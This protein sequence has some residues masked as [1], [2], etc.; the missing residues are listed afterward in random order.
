MYEAYWKLERKPFNNSKTADFYY[1]SEAHQGAVLKLRY[2]I[3][4]RRGGAVLAGA[5]GLGKTSLINTLLDQMPESYGPLIH[6]V[7]PQMPA[8]QLLA[9]LAD[10][11]APSVTTPTARTMDSCVRRIEHALSENTRAGRHAVV[12]ID[13]AH[14]LRDVDAQELLRLLL[15]FETDG[16]P[17]LTL[18][19]VGQPSVLAHLE[20]MPGLDERIGVKCLLR[21]FSGDETA[22]YVSHRLTA[23]GATRSLFDDAALET[24]HQL[25]LGVPR[26]INR[27][28][29]LALLIGFAEEQNQIHADHVEAVAQEMVTIAPE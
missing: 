29:D 7:F 25:S 17:D 12:V 15:N 21:P 9:Y 3:E 10:E 13:E 2:T 20:R 23:A 8:D 11:V 16:E 1:P 24:I 18:I 22:S 19:L 6:V 5:A 27:L 28:C 14:I 26:R 4:N